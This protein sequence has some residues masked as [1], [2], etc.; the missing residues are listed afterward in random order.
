[1]DGERSGEFC[2]DNIRSDTGGDVVCTSY[3]KFLGKVCSVEWS[4]YACASSGGAVDSTAGSTTA[5]EWTF[6]EAEH[7][8][9]TATSNHGVCG[10]FYTATADLTCVASSDQRSLGQTFSTFA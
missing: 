9:A 7:C 3:G 1:M 2:Q 4:T 5:S 8:S 6:T 10:I